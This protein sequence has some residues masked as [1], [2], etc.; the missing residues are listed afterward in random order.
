M[1][2]KVRVVPGVEECREVEQ[3]G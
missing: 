1:R 3:E 2:W